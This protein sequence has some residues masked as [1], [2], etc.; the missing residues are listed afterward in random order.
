MFKTITAKLT[1]VAP[2]LMHNGQLADPRNEVVKA[3][4]KVTG[5]KT[6]VEED[7]ILLSDLEWLGSLYTSEPGEVLVEG[8]SVVVAGWGHVVLPSEAIEGT[9]V[10]G[11][12]Q[13]KLGKKFLGAVFCDAAVPL[14]YSGPKTIEDLFNAPEF[15]DVRRVKVQTSAVQRTRPIFRDWSAVVDINFLPDMVTKDQ[16]VDALVAAGRTVGL[17][18][19]RP[20]FGRFTV[21]VQ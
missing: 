13:Q 2:L 18:D 21:E 7:H 9:L 6:K 5:K 10:A 3:I 15:R 20:K 8:T 11:A 1:G 12:K 16:L 14:Q 19:F 4:K 17:L